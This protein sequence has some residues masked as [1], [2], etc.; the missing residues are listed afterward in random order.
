MNREHVMAVLYDMAMVVGGEVELK[1]LLTRC[2]QR[3]LYHTSFP[4]G[5]V[6]LDVPP[7]A[8]GDVQARL[9]LAIGDHQLADLAGAR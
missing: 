3:L 8:G 7:A 2:L 4:V 1:P 9:E 6:F 5:L